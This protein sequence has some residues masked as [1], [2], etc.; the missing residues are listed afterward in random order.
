MQQSEK[1]DLG[2]DFFSIGL[3]ATGGFEVARDLSWR[4]ALVLMGESVMQ[5]ASQSRGKGKGNVLESI[6]GGLP[7][8]TNLDA[9]PNTFVNVF[10][11][12]LIVDTKLKGVAV[13]ELM[14]ARILVSGRKADMVE[15]SARAALGIL[16]V[17]FATEFAPDLRV[18]SGHDL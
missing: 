11:S 16:Y 18:G 1:P 15:K 13:F 5:C 8:A 3:E 6:R 2:A 14:W 9:D 12:T 7:L 10:C 17:K 4:N